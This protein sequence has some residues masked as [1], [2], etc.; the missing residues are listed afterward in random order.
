MLNPTVAT[1]TFSILTVWLSPSVPPVTSIVTLPVAKTLWSSFDRSKW[2]VIPDGVI[3]SVWI[4]TDKPVICEPSPWN[5][6]AVTIPVQRIPSLAV[7]TPIESTFFT[8]SYVN[9]PPTPRLPRN[10]AVVPVNPFGKSAAPPDWPLKSV[11]V[12]TPVTSKPLVAVGAPLAVL[13]VI[14]FALNL[15]MVYIFS[16]LWYE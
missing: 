4:P 5:A 12:Q 6:V 1:P 16:Y 13:F 14:V 9:T 3:A 8:S 7:I 11:A 2:V 10:V 15:D